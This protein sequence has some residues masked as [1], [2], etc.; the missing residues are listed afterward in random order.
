MKKTK[1]V[2]SC[3][4]VIAIF[5][6]SCSNN[7]DE[8]ISNEVLHIGDMA[9]L[10]VNKSIS[11]FPIIETDKKD[12]VT[13]FFKEVVSDNRA[14]L[15]ICHLSYGSR[16]DIE[17]SVLYQNN[18]YNVPFMIE[19]CNTDGNN[20]LLDIDTYKDTLGYRI[21]IFQLSPY[22]NEPIETDDYKIKL[23]VTKL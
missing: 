16:A 5:L 19:G 9:I 11:F 20:N 12:S 1:L 17:I 10:Q 22:P 15:S 8:N 13:V 14:P 7:D 6:G 23:Q 4:C 18:T 21:H 3:F 2:L